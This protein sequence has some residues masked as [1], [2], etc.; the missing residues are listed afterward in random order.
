MEL[1]IQCV[2]FNHR[3]QI[4]SNVK[5]KNIILFS[6]Q[7]TILLKFKLKLYFQIFVNEIVQNTFFFNFS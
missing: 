2:S 6:F 3:I 1:S 4:V 5:G 7:H